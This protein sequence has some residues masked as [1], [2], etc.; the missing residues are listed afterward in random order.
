MT[1]RVWHEDTYFYTNS[2]KMNLKFL[3]QLVK[4]K[5]FYWNSSPFFLTTING[6]VRLIKERELFRLFKGLYRYV[7]NVDGTG[8]DQSAVRVSARGVARSGS[9]LTFAP[10]DVFRTVGL[11]LSKMLEPFSYSPL[12]RHSIDF[13]VGSNPVPVTAFSPRTGQET[14]P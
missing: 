5:L 14:G 7:L 12:P 2:S 8:E 3:L 13:R 11:R 10:R 1:S 4:I 9:F 6:F